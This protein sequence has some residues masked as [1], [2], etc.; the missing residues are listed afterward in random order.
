VAHDFNNLL[1]AILSSLE[2]MKKRM[3]ED[4]RL[5][6][7]HSNAVQA[8]ERGA[9]LTQ[10]ML[11]FARRQDLD[12]QPVDLPRLVHGMAD[13]LQRSLGPRVTI[14]SRFPLLLPPVST[15]ANQLETALLNLA[16]NA[17][18]AMPDGGAITI[19]ARAETVAAGAVLAPGSYVCL[20]VTDTGE[21][22]DP[23]TLGRATEPF[24][25]TKGIGKGTG[26]GLSMV[27]GLA[28]QSGGGLVLK[29]TPGQG[30]TVELWLPVAERDIQPAAMADRPTTRVPRMTIL[31]VDDDALV[32]MNTTAMLEDLGHNVHEA[33]TGKQALDILR[34]HD[35][36]DLVITDHAMPGM[37]GS[38]LAQAI[39]KEWPTLPVVIAT[40]YAELPDGADIGLPRLA[41]PFLQA[42][43]ARLLTTVTAGKPRRG[44]VVEWPRTTQS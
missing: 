6:R 22:M 44:N 16:V 42:D 32:L 37:T 12:R 17:R 35:D 30:T 23:A 43:L 38:A 36:I 39:I 3:P 10:R 21:G 9:T 41:K 26:L 34:E 4:P 14:D 15:D 18:D 24:F 5:M 19:A 20:S 8:A 1:M 2:L 29:S 7:L 28:E 31:A 11:A 13:L 33:N 40:G 27:H 25:T